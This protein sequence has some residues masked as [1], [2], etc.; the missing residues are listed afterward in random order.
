[1][2]SAGSPADAIGGFSQRGILSEDVMG[3]PSDNG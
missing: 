3:H 1:M 2:S